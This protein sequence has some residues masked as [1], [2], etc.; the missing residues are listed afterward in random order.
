MADIASLLAVSGQEL[1]YSRID[2][3]ID[4]STGNLYARDKKTNSRFSMKEL[5]TLA[6]KGDADAQCAMAGYYGGE[7]RDFNI[8]KLT[9]WYEKAAVQ[10]NAKAQAYLAA[11]YMLG[12]GLDTDKGKAAYWAQKA[13]LQNSPIGILILI[14]CCLEKNDYVS[15]EQWLNKAKELGFP[16]P[17]GILERLTQAYQI[18]S[19][20]NKT[21]DIISDLIYLSDNKLDEFIDGLTHDSEYE[22]LI[23]LCNDRIAMAEG[24]IRAGGLHDLQVQARHFTISRC[25]FIRKKLENA[26]D[27]M[28]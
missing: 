12:L 28:V 3:M 15:A 11:I 23:G 5:E 16:D 8:S 1:E 10:G 13:A 19:D 26:G 22:D 2:I 25:E 24:A 21:S 18:L 27:S 6:N 14:M 17:D 7:G 9:F 20:K 4:G